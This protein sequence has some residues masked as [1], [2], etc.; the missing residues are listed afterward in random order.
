M[1]EAGREKRMNV[2]EFINPNQE[3]YKN[4]E[5]GSLARGRLAVDILSQE[6]DIANSK[7]LDLGCGTGGIS[8]ALAK[9]G[10]LVRAVDFD[11]RQIE[12][13]LNKAPFS[14]F[15][16]ETVLSKAED[17]DADH[18]KQDA[19]IL[20]DV[21]EHVMNP[22]LVLKNTKK[23]LERN[24][25]LLLSTPS[26]FSFINILC[27]PHYSLPVLSL[28]K[29]RFVKKIVSEWLHWHKRDKVDFAQLLSFSQLKGMLEDADFEW[30]F[31]NRK[32]VSYALQHPESLWSRN[33]HLKTVQ[34]LNKMGLLKL[35]MYFI[36]DKQGFFNKWINPT[37][38][39]LARAKGM[40]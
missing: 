16:I 1:R 6:I 18:I 40:E 35:I 8:I 38:F 10:A 12:Q 14:Q 32:V 37:W 5:L 11:T 13:L 15:R 29:R 34:T 9:A 31:I 21:I 33:W 22:E 23:V 25:L 36:N 7:V 39:I 27:D 26:R 4:Y 30:T 24:G 17:Y 3:L 19:V 20:F 28:L 2:L